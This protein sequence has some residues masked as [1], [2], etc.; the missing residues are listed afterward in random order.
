MLRFHTPTELRKT[1]PDSLPQMMV[2]CSSCRSNPTPENPVRALFPAGSECR[3]APHGSDVKRESVADFSW[4]VPWQDVTN[5]NLIKYKR[6]F[7]LS[8]LVECSVCVGK[9]ILIAVTTRKAAVI[10]FHAD[11]G[12]RVINALWAWP[13]LAQELGTV[14]TEEVLRGKLAENEVREWARSLVRVAAVAQ[15]EAWIYEYHRR[16]QSS[17]RG[18][19]LLRPAMTSEEETQIR[20]LLSDAHEESLELLQTQG[21]AILHGRAPKK[22]SRGRPGRPALK[23][24]LRLLVK[25]KLRNQKA[26]EVATAKV[27]ALLKVLPI[28]VSVCRDLREDYLQNSAALAMR[29]RQYV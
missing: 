27:G 8:P 4:I 26:R 22:R 13:E 5:G 3:K 29:L 1:L 11:I 6:V 7:G 24:V 18:L 10:P 20:K 14:T 9:R 12:G 16:Q 17:G 19:D 23:A 28:V 21:V 15:R 2:P 25:V